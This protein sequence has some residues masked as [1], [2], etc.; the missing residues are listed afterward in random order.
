MLCRDLKLYP[1]KKSKLFPCFD[2][3]Y[4]LKCSLQIVYA[5]R[6]PT[7][8]QGHSPPSNRRNK[9]NLLQT[10]SLLLLCGGV[11]PLLVELKILCVCAY[12]CVCAKG[13][14]MNEN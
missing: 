1:S 14:V 3:E 8:F 11:C 12:M 2:G 13:K 10:E 5:L 6:V 9:Q 4:N 7:I